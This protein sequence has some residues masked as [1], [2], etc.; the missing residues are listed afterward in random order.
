MSPHVV[1]IAVPA[2]GHVLPLLY[3][4]HKAASSGI[5]S[6][7]IASDVPLSKLK[8]SGD[9]DALAH[10]NLRIAALPHQGSI[11]WDDMTKGVGGAIMT[12]YHHMIVPT[13]QNLRALAKGE[14]VPDALSGTHLAAVQPITRVVASPFVFFGPPIAKELGLKWTT[15]M[16]TGVL[17]AVVTIHLAHRAVLAEERGDEDLFTSEEEG[18]EGQALVLGD[19]MTV[20]EPNEVVRVFGEAKL[21]TKSPTVR[22]VHPETYGQRIVD[23]D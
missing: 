4:A 14:S 6:T 15:F 10:T 20:G 17:G 2:L 22:Y 3:L 19:Y 9:L 8:E 11:T 13:Q 21:T 1:F 16:D 5:L 12:L 18:G 7:F 23:T